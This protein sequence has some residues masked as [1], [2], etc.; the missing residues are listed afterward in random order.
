MD[1]IS[2][3]PLVECKW[4][5]GKPYYNNLKIEGKYRYTGCNA[6]A[7]AQLYYYWG[8]QRG[9][10]RGCKATPKYT[11]ATNG[12]VIDSM[13][14]V[15][16]F[17]FANMTA[18]KPTTTKG[19]NA[20]A[21]LFSYCAKAMRSDFK[22]SS[23]SAKRTLLE[24]VINGTFRMGNSKHIYKANTADFEQ[25]IY[26]D[27]VA[28]RPVIMTSS[29]HTFLVDGYDAERK[30]YHINW[31]W[32][33]QDDG[34]FS[35]SNLKVDGVNYGGSLMA[36]VHIEPQYKLGDAT[37]DGVIDIGDVMT[38]INQANSGKATKQ[39]DIN[40]DGKTTKE[41]AEIIEDYLL[42]GEGL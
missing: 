12:F 34:Y 40:S 28:G 33:G 23:T 22:A 3:K 42:T 41:D 14:P 8:V 32:G 27:I 21:V 25:Q 36:V 6:T 30:M 31:G 11:T 29:S 37:G 13:P 10:H 9:Y 18:K 15:T 26:N 19:K 16:C 35:L 7:L 17:D 20:V 2:I 1:R 38:V 5:Q 4:G 39:T 24:S